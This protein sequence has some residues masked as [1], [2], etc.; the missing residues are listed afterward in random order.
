[1]IAAFMATDIA[2]V[3]KIRILINRKHFEVPMR[4]SKDSAQ[5]ELYE[6]GNRATTRQ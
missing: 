4:D 2:M 5:S 3:V 6:G 1:M